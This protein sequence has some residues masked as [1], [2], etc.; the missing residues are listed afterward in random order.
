MVIE[1]IFTNLWF[2]GYNFYLSKF[3]DNH[4]ANVVLLVWLSSVA[5]VSILEIT[6]IL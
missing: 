5:V 2:L 4:L 3:L 1:L 6:E